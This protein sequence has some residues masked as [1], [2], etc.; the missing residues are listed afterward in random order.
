MGVL[1]MRPT[2]TQHRSRAPVPAWTPPGEDTRLLRPRR[3]LESVA[4]GIQCD[5]TPAPSITYA[6]WRKRARDK[7]ACSREACW[8]DAPIHHREDAGRGRRPGENLLQQLAGRAK[9]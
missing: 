9:R 7:L 4:D 8:P 5:K 6:E 2:P 1:R 3:S